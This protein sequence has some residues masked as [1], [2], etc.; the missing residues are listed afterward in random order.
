ME[1]RLPTSPPLSLLSPG[2]DTQTVATH[3]T[4]KSKDQTHGANGQKLKSSPQGLYSGSERVPTKGKTCQQP[5]GLLG[6]AASIPHTIEKATSLQ[7]F[8]LSG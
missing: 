3:R 7:I 4:K 8:F 6:R 5:S 1:P 2:L